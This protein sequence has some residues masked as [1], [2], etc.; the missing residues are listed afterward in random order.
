[1]KTICMVMDAAATISRVPVS[2]FLNRQVA[3]LALFGKEPRDGEYVAE[4]GKL[5]LRYPSCL[6]K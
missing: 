3:V 1:M 6:E 5:G 2:R 4:R